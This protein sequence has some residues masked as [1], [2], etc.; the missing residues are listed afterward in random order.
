MLNHEWLETN[1][2]GG[3]G[4]G[5]VSGELRR[6]WHGILWNPRKPPR[7]RV[8]LIAG[9]EELL[10]H[11]VQPISLSATWHG[12]R[13][14]MPGAW[15]D[16]T[17]HPMPHWSWELEGGATLHKRIVMK[18]GTTSSVSV[19]YELEASDEVSELRIGVSAWLDEHAEP[20]AA[21]DQRV[22]L[23]NWPGREV[24]VTSNVPIALSAGSVRSAIVTLEV[25]KDCE[26][27]FTQ[28]LQLAPPV[29]F[30][31]RGGAPVVLH[32]SPQGETAPPP[33]IVQEERRRRAS[34]TVNDLPAQHV[35][36]AGRLGHAA[37]QFIVSVGNKGKKTIMAGYPWFTDWGR[38]TMIALPGLCLATGRLPEARTILQH[39]LDHTNKGVIPNIFPEAGTPPEYNTVDATLWMVEAFFRCNPP[40][41]FSDSDPN[42]H[43]L[44]EILYHYA[45]GTHN[46]IHLQ[47]D[48]L[49]WAGEEGSQLTWMDV[50]VNGEVPTPRHGK[51]VEIQ[52]LWYN[53]LR[54]MATTAKALGESKRGKQYQAQAEK[55]MFGFT[56][57]FLKNGEEAAADV[58]DRDGPRTEDWSI[59]PN[60]IIPFALT[61]NL[62]P[63]DRHPAILRAAAKHLATPRGLRT[64][65]PQD[66]RYKGVYR[67]NVLTRDRAYHQGTV[68]MWLA[69]PYLKGVHAERKRLP[70]LYAEAKTIVAEMIHHFEREG[71]VNQCSEIF[72]GDVPHHPRGCFAQAWSTAALIEVLRLD[73]S[74]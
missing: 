16:F 58:V 22:L 25:E 45:E 42:W 6:K 46:H 10:L 51:A 30:V 28:D 59:R 74:H 57:R 64:L 39:F 38:D 24:A 18:H 34:L 62:I 8:R 69:G 2:T 48:H 72:D 36:L 35:G 52:A 47:Q 56:T 26:D 27:V 49:L 61:H 11:P 67:G 70:A 50:K 65:S 44:Q 9:L 1:G 7:D 14:N 41:S 21:S 17:S 54:L 4:C 37:D 20:L 43:T 32:F 23:C 15:P 73:W 29:S 60:M 31:L 63:E 5:A 55:V 40:G 71:C 13:W 12:G 53:A 33:T 66:P 68:W 19:V 3:F